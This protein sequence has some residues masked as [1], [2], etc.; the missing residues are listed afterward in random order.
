MGPFALMLAL[1]SLA[2][3]IAGGLALRLVP[4]LR[5][6]SPASRCSPRACR[7]SPSWPRG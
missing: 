5:L 7:S 3:G 1:C 6:A 2:A 4:S